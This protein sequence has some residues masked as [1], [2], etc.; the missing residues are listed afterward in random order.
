MELLNKVEVFYFL[1]MQKVNPLQAHDPSFPKMMTM[2]DH[3]NIINVW[4]N[5][6]NRNR[7]KYQSLLLRRIGS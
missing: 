2:I 4:H 3:V 6:I 5:I 7:I 1:C